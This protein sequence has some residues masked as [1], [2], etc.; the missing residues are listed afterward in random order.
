MANSDRMKPEARWEVSGYRT[1]TA[2]RLDA[3]ARRRQGLG[4]SFRRLFE[5]FD[6]LVLPTAQ[7]FPFPAELHWPQEVAG[8]PMDT[9]HRWMEVTAPATLAGLPVL[10]VPVP[11]RGLPVGL[12]VLGPEGSEPLLLDV[13]AGWQQETAGAPGTALCS[14][15]TG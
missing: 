2:D 8:R 7:V 14:T 13:A 15:S 1:L 5:T 10:A 12:Q 4:E 11:T 6:V 3:M 9:Y